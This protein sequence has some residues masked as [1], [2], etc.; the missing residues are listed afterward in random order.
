MG[1]FEYLILHEALPFQ[2]NSKPK[3]PSP[4]ASKKPDSDGVVPP[5]PTPDFTTSQGND[6]QPPPAGPTDPNAGVDPS[7]GGDMSGADPNSGGDISPDDGT[8]GDPNAGTD[9]SVGGDVASPSQ[10]EE[11]EQ[12]EKDVF[13][14]L[15]PEQ[16]SIKNDELRQQFK[17]LH[18]TIVSSLEKI[19]KISHTTY[20]DQMLDFIVKKMILLKGMIK[21]TL[22]DS[23]RYRTYIENRV[24]LQR[25][26]TVF[27]YLTNLLSEIY[28]SRLKR[29]ERIKEISDKNNKKKFSNK[30]QSDKLPEFYQ[31]YDIQ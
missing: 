6:P 28:Q 23:F 16:M 13:A 18:D 19:N 26:T 15:K 21:D 4:S 9:P 8:G 22:I 14:D 3:T 7:A 11:I 24:E 10:T 2:D 30:K 1:R 29:Q 12:D 31:G 25:M 5:A 17:S 27:N 20:D